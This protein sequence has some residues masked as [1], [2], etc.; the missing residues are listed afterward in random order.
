MYSSGNIE[1]SVVKLRIC[2]VMVCTV[3]EQYS[4]AV[5]SKALEKC[6]SVKWCK[7]IKEFS[8]GTVR[9]GMVVLV[10]VE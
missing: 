4:I 1:S 8:K 7:G 9:Y 5:N 10:G 6:S 2:V 3:S